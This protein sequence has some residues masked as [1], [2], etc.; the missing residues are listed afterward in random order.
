MANMISAG[1][2]H[3]ATQAGDLDQIKQMIEEDA[4]QIDAGD[5]DGFT[6]LHIAAFYKYPKIVTFLINKK[7]HVNAQAEDKATPLHMAVYF[8]QEVVNRRKSGSQI[9]SQLLNSNADPNIADTAGQTPLHTLIIKHKRLITFLFNRESQESNTILNIMYALLQHGAQ[10]NIRDQ[11]TMAPIHYAILGIVESKPF[12]EGLLQYGGDPEIQFGTT[13]ETPLH[14]AVKTGQQAVCKQLVEHNAAV[15]VR[16]NVNTT[17]L[18]LASGAGNRD[19]V[20]YLLQNNARAD[21]R[22]DHGTEPIHNAAI[23]GSKRVIDLLIQY[24]ADVNTVNDGGSRPMHF[25]AFSGSEAAVQ[26]LLENA[27]RVNVVNK[28]GDTPLHLISHIEN[29]PVAPGM[30]TR[31]IEGVVTLLVRYGAFINVKNAAYRTPIHVAASL[32]S[33]DAIKALKKHGARVNVHAYNKDRTQGDGNTPLHE[34]AEGNYYNVCKVL[35]QSGADVFAVDTDGKTPY[36]VAQN[37]DVRN[38]LNQAMQAKRRS[39]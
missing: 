29:L 20:A 6:P 2:I 9:V 34:A 28:N 33:Y 37:Q 22:D 4:Q 10:P 7:A 31:D 8:H 32:G 16:D 24:G 21:A 14:L 15:N 35:I 25:A 30:Y 17:P 12:V 38:L 19:I 27:A 5:D 11:L 18:H 3:D 26:E 13:G 39:E 23:S 1:K 36:D